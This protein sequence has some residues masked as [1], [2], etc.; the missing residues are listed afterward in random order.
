MFSD[1]PVTTAGAAAIGADGGD[2]DEEEGQGAEN[3]D[4][5]AAFVHQLPAPT[6]ASPMQ[7][8]PMPFVH[9]THGAES[10]M[11]VPSGGAGLGAA[12]HSGL[13]STLSSRVSGRVSNTSI[14]SA[15]AVG[16][17]G[18]GS[19]AAHAGGVVSQHSWQRDEY[20][21]RSQRRSL[22]LGIA[23]VEATALARRVS[24][25]RSSGEAAGGGG[26]QVRCLLWLDV[27]PFY[28]GFLARN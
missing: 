15:T 1:A 24:S 12:G 20:R 26:L 18:V 7:G 6:A 2:D 28:S 19:G 23:A 8:G 14:S 21:P 22:E 11:T 13:Q 16:A 27:Q 3:E 9:G 25:S 17:R 4:E 5:D 10:L